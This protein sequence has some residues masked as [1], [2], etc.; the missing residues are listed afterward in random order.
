MIGLRVLWPGLTPRATVDTD[1]AANKAWFPMLLADDI[2]MHTFLFG[3]L[4]HK[5]LN[6]IKGAGKHDNVTAT[7]LEKDMER[8]EHAAIA[9]IN[10]AL[11]KP[12]AVVTDAIIVSVLTLA[13]NS[14]DLRLKDFQERPGPSPIFDPLLK[15]L[16][17]LDLYGLLSIHPQHAAGLVQLV[18]RRGG[19]YNIHTPG[20]AATVSL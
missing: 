4:S 1:A 8:C 2:A 17:W 5:R 3:A 20:L 14:W 16:Q 6:L 18:E 11:S 12:D 9:R 15:S 13:A 7:I 10:N 19:L